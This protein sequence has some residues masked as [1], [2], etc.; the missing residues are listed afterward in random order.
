MQHLSYSSCAQQAATA[1]GG[2]AYVT[3][4]SNGLYDAVRED[5]PPVVKVDSLIDLDVPM[6][7]QT[8]TGGYARAACN[9]LDTQKLLSVCMPY[10]MHAACH[11]MPSVCLNRSAAVAA[12]AADVCELSQQL[13][14]IAE[15]KQPADEHS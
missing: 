3:L 10:G 14:T 11:L 5:A 12:D 8:A 1:G 7:E 13:T 4:Q 6:S 15:E 9:D 2:T